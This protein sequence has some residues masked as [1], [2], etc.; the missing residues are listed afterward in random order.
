MQRVVHTCLASKQNLVP[1]TL[2]RCGHCHHVIAEPIL[3]ITDTTTSS[4]GLYGY[5]TTWHQAKNKH[6]GAVNG[7]SDSE[8]D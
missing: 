4:L 8:S 5:T 6:H 1:I 7:A 3:S 2:Q